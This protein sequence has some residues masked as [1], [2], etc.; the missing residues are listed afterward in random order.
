MCLFPS[1]RGDFVQSFRSPPSQL[2]SYAR[3]HN[4][5]SLPFWT[6][7]RADCT[8]AT[9]Y[10]RRVWTKEEDYAIK[11]LVRTHGTR[12]WA[13]IEEHLASDYFI[14]GRSGKQCRERW[15]NHLGE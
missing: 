13:T 8:G 12:S 3:E 4:T 5:S 9:Y 1:R 15:H 2:F 14:Q 7:P 10:S 11:M 6:P